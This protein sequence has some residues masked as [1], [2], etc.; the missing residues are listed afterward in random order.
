MKLQARELILLTLML[1]LL[2]CSWWFGFKRVG[3]RKEQYRRE[4]A[5]RH[6]ELADLEQATAGIEDL[7][8][9]I[10]ELRRAVAFF[11]AKLPREKNVQRTLTDVWRAAEKNALAISRFEPQRVRRDSHYSEQPIKLSL[12]GDFEGFYAY[13][14]ELERMDR[15]TRVTKLDVK[16]IDDR[17]G[18][19]EAD[20]TLCIFF[21]PA[22]T[23]GEVVSAG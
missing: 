7:D 16:K 18:Q 11:E 8:R 4:I 12:V 5:D 15:I 10:D 6:R 21:E 1:A 13:L 2:G 14:L 19:T 20:M 23:A 17:D 22:G 3:E 9:R